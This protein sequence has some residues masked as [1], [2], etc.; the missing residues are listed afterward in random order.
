MNFCK[1]S[2]NCIAEYCSFRNNGDDDMA[3]W[4]ADG[5]QCSNNTYRYN[6]A[7]NNYRSS[8]CSLYG[9]FGNKW[10]NII[11]KD[12]YEVGIRANSMFQG[13][14]YGD[15]VLNEFSNIDVIGCGTWNNTYGNPDPAVDI[16]KIGR[17]HV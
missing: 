11:V 8:S 5:Q 14:C 16:T 15:G 1:G 9:G 17:A 7:E 6:T 4:P 10:Q 2:T 12:N 3:I 13:A